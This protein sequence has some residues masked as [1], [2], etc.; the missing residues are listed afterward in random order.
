LN[1]DILG[2]VL[3]ITTTITLTLIY[4]INRKINAVQKAEA[5]PV[6]AT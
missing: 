5:A 6:P 2:Y 1:F 3:V 4:F